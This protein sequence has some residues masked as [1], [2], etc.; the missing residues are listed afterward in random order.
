MKL[1]PLLENFD[2]VEY[3][4]GRLNAFDALHVARLI[5][6]LAPVLFGEV[7]N[8]ISEAI[9]KSKDD[10]TAS[11]LDLMNE[12]GTFIR[13]AEPVLY[14]LSLLSRPDFESMVKTCLS[15]VERKV[16]KVW[17]PV[18]AGGELAYADMDVATIIRLTIT[19]I[20]REI[21]PITAVLLKLGESKT[22]E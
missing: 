17:T 10:S 16:N 9:E 8:G 21:R 20:T 1:D 3:Q 5:A 15:C 7:L 19:V 14:R 4:V 13:I 11:A 6:P 18:I 2:G 22:A 12:V